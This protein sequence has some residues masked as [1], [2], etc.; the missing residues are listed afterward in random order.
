M[1]MDI[2]LNLLKTPQF[3]HFWS[4][5]TELL[6]FTRTLLKDRKCHSMDSINTYFASAHQELNFFRSEPD[7]EGRLV[8]DHVKTSFEGAELPLHGFIEKEVGVEVNKLLWIGEEKTTRWGKKIKYKCTWENYDTDIFVLSFDQFDRLLSCL[9]VEYCHF[10]VEIC[11]ENLKIYLVVLLLI[12]G[13]PFELFAYFLLPMT[14]KRRRFWTNLFHYH[15]TATICVI[16]KFTGCKSAISIFHS[17]CA[18]TP[19]MFCALTHIASNTER[20]TV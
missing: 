6:S 4:P 8:R 10:M 7:L 14:W 15:F 18:F 17:Q 16:L 9:V 13:D 11:C 5:T 19:P 12:C 1:W 2:H 20:D 3:L